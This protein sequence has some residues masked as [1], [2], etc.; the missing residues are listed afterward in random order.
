MTNITEEKSQLRQRFRVERRSRFSEDQ[1]AGNAMPDFFHLLEIP[2][3]RGA[4]IV[5]SYLSVKDEP[6]TA[7]LNSS[8]L[9]AGKMLLLPRVAAQ[10]LEWAS[11]SGDSAMLTENRG[12]L[13][14]IGTAFVEF[15]NIDAVIVPSLQ[16]DFQGYRLGQGGGYYDRSLPKMGGWKVGIVYAEEFTSVALPHEAHDVPLAAV[17]TPLAV[18]RFR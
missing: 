10:N 9:A 13:E 7:A 2:E 17:V 3:I 16:I 4:N 1:A 8:L 6:N 5:T 12:L 11:W 14:P 18:T 15:S